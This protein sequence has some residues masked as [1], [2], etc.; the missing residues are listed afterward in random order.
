[1]N[2]KEFI[3]LVG[4]S[5]F[6][7]TPASNWP[8]LMA[9]GFLRPAKILERN[10]LQGS[11]RTHPLTIRTAKFNATLNHQRPL[12]EGR[13]HESKFLD[14]HT[15][16]SWAAQLDTR[17]FF[18]PGKSDEAFEKSLENCSEVRVV[19]FD[20]GKIFEEF[21][22][23]VDIAPIN[24]GSARRQPVRR[25]DWIY[26]S[27]RCSVVDFQHNRIRRKLV[28]YPDR[29]KEVSLRADIPKD[30]LRLLLCD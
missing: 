25:G 30:T 10:G 12:L 23:F 21:R 28:K 13:K 27:A 2:Q 7:V 9:C 4:E 15:I 24:T 11:V 8:N 22:D 6:H 20:A 3:S 14:K 19:K 16:E 17:I 18:W 26:V 1:M 5:L 29:V